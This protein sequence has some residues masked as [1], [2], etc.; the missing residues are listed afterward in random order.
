VPEIITRSLSLSELRD[1]GKN[2][3]HHAGEHVVTWV[4]SCWDYGG[5]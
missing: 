4:L 3:S 5:Q 2:F 1:T